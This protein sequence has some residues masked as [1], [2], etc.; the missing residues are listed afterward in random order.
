MEADC[1]S[2]WRDAVAALLMKTALSAGKLNLLKLRCL[3][4]RSSRVFRPHESHS[5]DP[6]ASSKWFRHCAERLNIP[7]AQRSVRRYD[8]GTM[9]KPKRSQESR[10]VGAAV[11]FVEARMALGR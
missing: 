1:L 6:Q 2:S 3:T 10:Q 4:A 5:P 11:A 8:T 9:K 7:F